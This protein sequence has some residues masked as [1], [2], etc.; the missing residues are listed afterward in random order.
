MTERYPLSLNAVNIVCF[1]IDWD[2]RA[3]KV[4][5]IKRNI[6]PQKNKWS[7]PGG[8]VNV[9][10]WIREVKNPPEDLKAR[11]GKPPTWYK[12]YDVPQFERM[13]SN[14]DGAVIREKESEYQKNLDNMTSEIPIIKLEG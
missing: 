10:G 6:T 8:F 13:I 3:L 14:P 4:L 11:R 5:L 12:E 9:D 2:E 1:K 7:L